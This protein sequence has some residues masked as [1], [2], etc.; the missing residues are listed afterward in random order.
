MFTVRKRQVDPE[1]PVCGVLV[2]TLRLC[3][4]CQLPVWLTA[5]GVFRLKAEGL[6]FPAES[7]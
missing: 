3:V 6:F 7:G 1:A 2:Q 5:L 4:G